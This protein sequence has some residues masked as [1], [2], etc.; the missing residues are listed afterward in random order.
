MT[1]TIVPEA[2]PDD[3]ERLDEDARRTL[4]DWLNWCQ[5]RANK[6]DDPDLKLKYE[7]RI[8]SIQ[9]VMYQCDV[10]IEY[11]WVGHEGKWFMAT[12]DDAIEQLAYLQELRFV[13]NVNRYCT[14]EL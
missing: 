11:G 4:V 3:Y 14:K 1:E 8:K 5:E 7:G 10:F 9:S 13:D 2:F 12:Y 6:T